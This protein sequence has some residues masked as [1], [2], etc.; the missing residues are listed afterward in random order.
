[1]ETHKEDELEDNSV[2]LEQILRKDILKVKIILHHFLLQ[3]E[4]TTPDIFNAV[5]RVRNEIH[6]DID[7]N[8]KQTTLYSY[9]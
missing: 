2:K 6:C 4:K 5:R 9:V 8:N 1:M 3:Y 7:F